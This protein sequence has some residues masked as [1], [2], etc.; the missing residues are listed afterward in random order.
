MPVY[1]TREKSVSPV[2]IID[3]KSTDPVQTFYAEGTNNTGHI[4]NEDVQGISSVQMR[5]CNTNKGHH[6]VL[7]KGA[8]VKA[9][10]EWI[11]TVTNISLKSH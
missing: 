4:G 9:T 7:G 8:L 3:E 2:Q 6:Q 10:F 5:M 11:N 1:N